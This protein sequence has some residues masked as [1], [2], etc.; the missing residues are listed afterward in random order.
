[1]QI[2]EFQLVEFTILQQLLCDGVHLVVVVGDDR[3]QD[4]E[5]LTDLGHHLL[6]LLF[7]MDDVVVA[8]HSLISIT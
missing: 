1:M 4:V 7:D 3:G 5:E 8:D 2:S 6:V